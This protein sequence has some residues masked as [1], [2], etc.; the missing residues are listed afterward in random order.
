MRVELYLYNQE[1]KFVNKST[2]RILRKKLLICLIRSPL[3]FDVCVFP[4]SEFET[5]MHPGLDTTLQKLILERNIKIHRV[6]EI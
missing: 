2:Y 3:R 4:V 5:F 1:R 6:A